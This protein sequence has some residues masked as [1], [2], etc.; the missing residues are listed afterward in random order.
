MASEQE[1]E[2][3]GWVAELAER[4]GGVQSGPAT[5][6]DGRDDSGLANDFTFG[7]AA[8]PLAVEITRLRDDFENPSLEEHRALEERLWRLG[9]PRLRLTRE[10]ESL[11]AA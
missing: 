8:P 11:Q 6:R 5:E 10:V 7:N 3:A 4:L 2:L 9:L 1:L